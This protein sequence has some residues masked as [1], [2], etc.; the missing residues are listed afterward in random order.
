MRRNPWPILMV[1][2][3]TI[4]STVAV[5]PAERSR[6]FDVGAGGSLVIMV[7]GD[8]AL[9]TAPGTQVTVQASGIAE[10][11]L[12]R[13]S[14]SQTGNT[15]T[16]E[17]KPEGGGSVNV[18]FNI[19]LPTHFDVDLTTSGGDI[20]LEGNLTGRLAGKTA[21]GDIRIGNVDGN[22]VLTTAG[23]DIAAGKIGGDA[24][25]KT[26]GGDIRLEW[27]DGQVDVSTAGG[28][29]IVGDVAR[30]L[31]ASTS[32]GDIRI[33]NVNGDATVSTA[34]GD[35]RVGKVSGS[36]RLNT[37]GGDIECQGASGV[38]NANTAGGDIRLTAISGSLTAN[39]AGGDIT[40]DL[41]P[42]GKGTSSLNTAGG[43]LTISLPEN[44]RARIEAVIEIRGR[45]ATTHDDY[46]I[47]S[48]F[49]ALDQVIDDQAKEI[50][51][52]YELNGGGELIKMKTSNGNI[53]I[54]K[55]AR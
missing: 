11:Q 16:V 34:G 41:T 12:G 42:S 31:K 55:A 53:S 1:A 20:T 30:S 25:L 50:R 9:R 37:A 52:V 49:R 3:L 24:K 38:V 40:A 46:Q 26:A 36:A 28:D 35:V 2:F 47:T 18:R 33:N 48:D 5:Y 14:M 6:T 19:T 10:D 23:G 21:G 32:G 54:R 27:S 13:L 29:I 17:Y 7:V 44:A 45:W 15:V 43:D 22:T 4:V 8:V 39:T 51:A